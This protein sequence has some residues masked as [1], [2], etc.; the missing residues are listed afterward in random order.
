MAYGSSNKNIATAPY[1]FISL[2]QS[3]VPSELDQDINWENEESDDVRELYG[4]Y[5]QKQGTLSGYIDL[6]ITTKTPCFIGGNGSEFFAPVDADKPLIPGSTIRGMT[7]NIFKII[8]CGAMRCKG[9][10]EED[11]HNQRLYFRDMASKVKS[12]KEH[13]E[14]Q[15]NIEHK[16]GA[17]GT[18]SVSGA[19]A[20]FLVCAGE[21]YYICPAKESREELDGKRDTNTVIW[22]MERG[23]CDC[24]TGEMG[25]KK[26]YDIIYDGNWENPLPV[27]DEVIKAYRED[28]KRGNSNEVDGQGNG[29]N[30]LT[31]AKRGDGARTFTE[32]YYD[33]VIP[34]FYKGKNG[35]VLHFGFGR[36]YRIPY[37]LAIAEHVPASLQRSCIDFS[38]AVFGKKELWGSR[39]FF[40]DALLAS[41][42]SCFDNADYTHP[43]M[44]PNP[45][46]FQLYLDQ[47]DRKEPAHWDDSDVNI[48]G[49]KMYWHHKQTSISWQKDAEEI[50][51]PGM[52]KIRPLKQGNVF[53]GKIRFNDL[54]AVEL[55]ALLKVFDLGV[56]DHEVCYKL[57]QG[58]P[59]GMGSVKIDT[60]LYI[61]KPQA[62]YGTLFQQDGWTK[63]AE[64]MDAEDCMQAFK[65]Y[66]NKKFIEADQRDSETKSGTNKHRYEI[67]QRDLCQMLDW[68]QR[69]KEDVV[70]NMKIEKNDR[71]FKD[72]YI[73]PTIS[74]ICDKEK[75]Q[76]K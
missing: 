48:R 5:I 4:E 13:Y 54:S 19:D 70:R 35:K 68:D 41:S 59:L 29:F 17:H 67:L 76:K 42:L 2:P 9:D 14:K 50:T 49:Y 27:P 23:S 52:I 20:G 63:S 43:L 71:G 73:L 64:K 21:K 22:N 75:L 12:L 34:C 36:F 55:G 25:S 60:S 58:K 47:T 6:T 11:F 57:G 10:V 24:F 26:H 72:R 46:S 38:D 7:K 30:L 37:N 69:K 1:N 18:Y 51:I 65:E 3:V 39:V 32:N 66:M 44:S 74:E 61:V 33:M 28:K 16:H 62:A 8:T 53:R 45:T 15:L 40:E 56:K 31:N